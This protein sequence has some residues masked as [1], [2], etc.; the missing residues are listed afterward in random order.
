MMIV[1]TAIIEKRN[2]RKI[3]LP[4]EIVSSLYV[5][6]KYAVP[7]SRMFNKRRIIIYF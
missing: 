5:T 2:E 1:I 6:N 7:P 3:I 4:K